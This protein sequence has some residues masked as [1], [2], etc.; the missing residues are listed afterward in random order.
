[1][2]DC[3][4]ETPSIIGSQRTSKQPIRGISECSSPRFCCP[5]SY[6]GDHFQVLDHESEVIY[7][8][9]ALLAAFSP[10]R[11]VAAPSPV[12]SDH[13][14]TFM[15]DLYLLPI[16]LQK[17]DHPG[18]TSLS[19][20]QG[21]ELRAAGYAK[22]LVEW[23]VH[24]HLG[25]PSTFLRTVEKHLKCDDTPSIFISCFEDLFEAL[26][27]LLTAHQVWP[28]EVNLLRIDLQHPFFSQPVYGGGGGPH[29]YRVQDILDLPQRHRIFG[30]SELL[31]QNAAFRNQRELQPLL[32]FP[33]NSEWLIHWN[34]HQGAIKLIPGEVLIDM[35][36]QREGVMGL[37]DR[38]Y[39]DDPMYGSLHWLQGESEL[40]QI[41]RWSEWNRSLQWLNQLIPLQQP[42][43]PQAQQWLTIFDAMNA[44]AENLF[45]VYAEDGDQSEMAGLVV[46]G[47][48]SAQNYSMASQLPQTQSLDA[49]PTP[50]F[51]LPSGSLPQN[52]LFAQND[53][54]LQENASD[55]FSP[56]LLTS[57]TF[58]NSP[59]VPG[60]QSGLDQFRQPNESFQH[61]FEG[62]QSTFTSGSPSIPAQVPTPAQQPSP[63]PRANPPSLPNIQVAASPSNTSNLNLLIQCGHRI[64]ILERISQLDSLSSLPH[65][66]IV[67]PER[68]VMNI[69]TMV[70]YDVRLGNLEAGF[71]QRGLLNSE[72]ALRGIHGFHSH[73]LGRLD[74][75]LKDLEAAIFRRQ[76]QLFGVE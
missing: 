72:G 52:D 37:E 63:A 32:P 74:S 69:Q 42:L 2:P 31:Q 40:T 15:R 48:N 36:T 53:F 50:S 14:S 5:K 54:S 33:Q 73:T 76:A 51:F 46:M 49:M 71:A 18:P 38:V 34:V 21:D 55:R 64:K 59:L 1:M 6:Q 62:E 16:S 56:D 44:S 29:A 66:G 8:I 26:N 19:N 65:S 10:E 61:A 22:S 12:E 3:Q 20:I 60:E 70:E 13:R 28:G 27:W 25:E 57:P 17:V 45:C 43:S 11:P 47:G 75:R 35:R 41:H 7:G 24:F 23:E 58:P 68:A 9:T 4:R 67:Q 39:F 30:W